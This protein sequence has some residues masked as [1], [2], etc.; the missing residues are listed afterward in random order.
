MSDHIGSTGNLN[1]VATSDIE[2]TKDDNTTDTTI[3][4]TRQSGDQPARI[5]SRVLK[6]LYEIGPDVN[7]EQKEI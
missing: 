6:D 5:L 1:A 3:P 2:E 4:K 7:E